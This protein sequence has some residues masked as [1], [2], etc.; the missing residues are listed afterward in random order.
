ML[1][2][3]LITVKDQVISE[4]VDSITLP[5]KSGQMTILPD[6][7]M[8]VSSLTS[9]NMYF[10]KIEPDGKEKVTFY[11]IGEGFVEVEKNTVTV[12]TQSA[13]VT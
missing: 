3:K 12:L 10:K 5:G 7:A 8:F 13:E 11:K 9:G 4:K 1:N 2:F 6:H